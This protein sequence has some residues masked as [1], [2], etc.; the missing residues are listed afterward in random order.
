MG[1]PP[2]LGKILHQLRAT[3]CTKTDPP[4][5][6]AAGMSRPTPAGSRLP[7]ASGPRGDPGGLPRV[8]AEVG[9]PPGSVG[10]ANPPAVRSQGN[11]LCGSEP[12][13]V[14]EVDRVG[15]CA[16]FL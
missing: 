9:L 1:A 13:L 14:R 2:G 6:G 12:W 10:G 15:S 3:S 5:G 7:P 16:S 4:P 8:F 11:P